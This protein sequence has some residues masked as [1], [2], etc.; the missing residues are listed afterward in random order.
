MYSSQTVWTDDDAVGVRFTPG[1][2][3]L[4]SF[5]IFVL[6]EFVG[7]ALALTAIA[8]TA[9]QSHNLRDTLASISLCAGWLV[10]LAGIVGFAFTRWARRSQRRTHARR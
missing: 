1:N 2:R 8:H 6:L 7:A 3:L 5:V 10:L 4:V 9:G